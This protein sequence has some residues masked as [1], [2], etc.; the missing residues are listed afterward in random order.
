MSEILDKEYIH[1]GSDKIYKELWTPVHMD[2]MYPNLKP[3]G[4]F[5][6]SEESSR[7]CYWLEYVKSKSEEEYEYY[8]SDK[9]GCLVKFKQDIRVLEIKSKE[10]FESLWDKDLIRDV[11]DKDFNLGYCYDNYKINSILDYEKISKIFDLIYINKNVDSSLLKMYIDN[12][13]IALNPNAIDYF[14]PLDIDFYY[15]KINHTGKKCELIEPT[16]DYYKLLNYIYDLFKDVEFCGNYNDYI[17]R[18]YK[19]KKTFFEENIDSIKQ[20]NFFMNDNIPIDKVVRVILET[21]YCE[22]Y[23]EKQKKLLKK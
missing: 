2:Q 9:N 17:E 23:Q 21:I 12:T 20:M 6:V 13:I 14:R 8:F 18:L 22:K 10:D 1:I 15:E 11:S 5:W 19:Y 3:Y 16:Q 7:I 4:G